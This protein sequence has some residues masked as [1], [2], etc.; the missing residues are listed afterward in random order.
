MKYLIAVC[1][2]PVA[3]GSSNPQTKS[4]VVPQVKIMKW[5]DLL[6][7]EQP[8]PDATLKYGEDPLQV[9]DV[10][11]PAGSTNA[12]AVIMIH[13]G[14]W[15]T[16][17]AKRDIM[18]WIAADLR[19]HGVGV[20]NIEYRGVDRKGGYP[21]TYQDVG[22]AADLF[23]EK[24]D[25][26]GFRKDKI[27]AIGHS[28]GGHL[29]LWL[30]NR[31]ALPKSEPLRGTN[32]IKVDLAISQGGLP[33]LKAGAQRDGHPCGTDAPEKMSAADLRITSPPEMQPGKARQVLF[34]NTRDRI[35]P[36]DYARAYI[37]RMA[38]RNIAVK[39]VETPDEGHV[40]LVTPDTKSWSKQRELILRELGVK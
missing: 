4:P 10:W 19:K 36:P 16:E 18:N 9:I 1:L 26:Y 33:D 5:K 27:V 37:A 30:A 25:E 13:G 24:A 29:A 17:I 38:S 22:K 7:R 14:C 11:Q 34:N 2:L 32:P 8:K 23:L 20:W 12:P 3:F 39:L 6:G 15:Q 35:A 28:A 21:A 31:T 40:E